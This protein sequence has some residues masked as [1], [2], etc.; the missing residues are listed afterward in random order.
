ML[1][2][3]RSLPR[4]IRA[5]RGQVTM[6]ECGAWPFT[7][8]APAPPQLLVL[9][10]APAALAC[11]TTA[12]VTAL[13]PLPAQRRVR[14][15]A[16]GACLRVAAA[17]RAVTGGLCFILRPSRDTAL[18]CLLVT[19]PL[20][21]LDQPARPKQAR[22]ADGGCGGAAGFAVVTAA[23]SE[24]FERLVNLVPAPRGGGG[25]SSWRG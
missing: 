7:M 1:L 6:M 3:R 16:H 4:W 10:P 18:P 24:Y 25:G 23:S 21:E 19:K 8:D 22:P 15:V 5:A 9:G 17:R 14:S 12:L 11:I 20:Q 13:Q 2:P